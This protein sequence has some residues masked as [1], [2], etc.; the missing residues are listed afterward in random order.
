MQ[1][2]FVMPWFNNLEQ[3]KLS[4][5]TESATAVE[6]ITNNFS[7]SVECLDK[8]KKNERKK[9]KINQR[10]QTPSTSILPKFSI[11]AKLAKL[12]VLRKPSDL[13]VSECD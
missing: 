11:L 10:Y 12:K 13:F 2:E 1:N 5:S 9:K 8:C 3:S 4:P 7:S 6:I